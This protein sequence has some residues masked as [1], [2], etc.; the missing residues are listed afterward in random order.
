MAPPPAP[1]HTKPMEIEELSSADTLDELDEISE[2]ASTAAGK[3]L[4]PHMPHVS[5]IEVPIVLDR[6][7]FSGDAPIEIKLKL[8]LK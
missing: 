2:E 3:P 1:V 4:V 8:Y 6:S 7:L 5:S